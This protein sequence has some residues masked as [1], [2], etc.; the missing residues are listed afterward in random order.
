MMTPAVS[1]SRE[2]VLARAGELPGFPRLVGAI[3]TSIDDPEANLNDLAGLIE[4]D[5]AIA[6]RVLAFANTAA[7]HTRRASAIRDLYTATSLIGLGHV[8]QIALIGA[9]LD[10]FDACGASDQAAHFSQHSVAV[11][12]CAEELALH[13][14]AP[15]SASNALV[16]GLLHDIGQLWLFRF[17]PAAECNAWDLALGHA[18]GIE[19][20]E[21]R[22]FGI[23]HAAI[24]GWLAAHW[25]LSPALVDAI[26][27]HH[28][29]DGT[30]DQVLTPVIHIAEVL[31]NALDLAGRKENRVVRL[32]AAACQKI[33]LT[34]RA[35]ARNLFGRID[36]RSRHA[37]T[38]F[39]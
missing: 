4:R 10:F 19:E 37:T 11:G 8:R 5:P 31:S 2:Q 23:D 13:I 33:G 14:A 36:A 29:C 24:G 18:E 1:I 30:L 6:A 39:A 7:E 9:C 32:S 15:I 20:T 22:T 3:L 28:A 26:R 38:F 35:D 25:G 12:I 17:H 21:R 34:W 16:A 27:H